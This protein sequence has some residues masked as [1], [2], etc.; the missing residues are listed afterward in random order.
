MFSFRAGILAV[1][2]EPARRMGRAKVTF[3]RPIP[4]AGSQ[5]AAAKIVARKFPKQVSLLAGLFIHKFQH[6]YDLNL[7]IN[8]SFFPSDM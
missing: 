3:P 6:S 4:L 2:V 7:D 8:S 5:V 1:E